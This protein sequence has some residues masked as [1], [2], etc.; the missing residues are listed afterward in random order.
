MSCGMCGGSRGN[1]RRYK[2]TFTD[3]TEKVFLSEVE[4]RVAATQAGGGRI[5]T[6]T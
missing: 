4:A 6:I 1:P 3:G 2:V 5:E